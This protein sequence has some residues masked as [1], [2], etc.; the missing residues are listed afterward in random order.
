MTSSDLNVDTDTEVTLR[1][2]N[3]GVKKIITSESDEASDE[4]VIITKSSDTRDDNM[5]NLS[6]EKKKSCTDCKK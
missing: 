6:P 1:N 3:E 4:E 2:D 5:K